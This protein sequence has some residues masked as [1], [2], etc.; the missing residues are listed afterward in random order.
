MMVG[1]VLLC[2]YSVEIF[3]PFQRSFLFLQFFC[4]WRV[5]FQFQGVSLQGNHG[6]WPL[7]K[8]HV[9]SASL[10]CTRFRERASRLGC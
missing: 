8:V 5:I 1:L 9:L 7:Q 10:A 4:Q 3:V 6:D 2:H